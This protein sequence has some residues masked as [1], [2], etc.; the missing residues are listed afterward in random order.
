M[1]DSQQA[2]DFLVT[3]AP[4]HTS[5]YFH[6]AIRKRMKRRTWFAVGAPGP[7]HLLIDPMVQ[8]AAGKY[9]TRNRVFSIRHRSHGSGKNLRFNV[10]GAITNCTS[11]HSMDR[12]LD[13][14]VSGKQD[15]SSG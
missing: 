12:L 7:I 4:D 10:F 6:F 14:I 1:A 13:I 3:H 2:C 9:M 11:Q 5:Q 8:L 15:D